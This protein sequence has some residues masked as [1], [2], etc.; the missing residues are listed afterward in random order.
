VFP[1]KKWSRLLSF[2]FHGS[3]KGA[4]VEEPLVRDWPPDFLD[5]S[6]SSE[7]G[8]GTEA[9]GVSFAMD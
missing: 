1:A 6:R 3:G 4:F 8:G 9:H 7:D 5:A 2:H